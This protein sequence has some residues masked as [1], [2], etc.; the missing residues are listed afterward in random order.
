MEIH[1]MIICLFSSSLE[2]MRNSIAAIFWHHQVRK[3][4]HKRTIIYFFRKKKCIEIKVTL[5]FLFLLCSCINPVLW[6]IKRHAWPLTQEIL[7][8]LTFV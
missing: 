7:K 8:I 3:V 1:T 5:L 6:P 4:A 2:K